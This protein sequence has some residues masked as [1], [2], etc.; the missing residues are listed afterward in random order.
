[1]Q[2]C[3]LQ[4][5]I[6]VFIITINKLSYIKVMHFIGV[7]LSPVVKNNLYNL[8]QHDRKALYRSNT[9]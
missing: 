9:M 3:L 1:M 7:I 8:N 5:F 4:K 6:F 2:T